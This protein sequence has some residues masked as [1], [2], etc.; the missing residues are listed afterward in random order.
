MVLC[1]TSGSSR[2]AVVVTAM[3]IAAHYQDVD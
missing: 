1:D 3:S 2:A